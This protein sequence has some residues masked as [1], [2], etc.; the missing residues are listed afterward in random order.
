MEETRVTWVS[1]AILTLLNKLIFPVLWFGVITGL[2]VW[3]YLT[4]ARISIASDF[5]F[6]AAFVVAASV[7]LVW[8]TIRLQRVGYRG[9]KLIIA[10]YWREAEIPFEDVE[11]VDPVWWYKGR[12]VRL[13][14]R[15]RTPFGYTVYYL[16][17]WGPLRGMFSSPDE[18]LRQVIRT[19]RSD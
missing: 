12:L 10:N 13:R 14:F 17:K 6:I 3:V 18:E 19:S 16:A 1:G 15:T 5:R 8:L 2:L 7:L 9:S 4:S 11:A